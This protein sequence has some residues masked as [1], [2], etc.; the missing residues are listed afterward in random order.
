MALKVQ[1]GAKRVSPSPLRR[2]EEQPIPPGVG[3][4][5]LQDPAGH[6]TV[7][8]AGLVQPSHCCIVRSWLGAGGGGG[9]RSGKPDR[10]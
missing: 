4:G 6:C 9:G 5:G 1:G 8:P 10:E 3:V 7:S 2:G